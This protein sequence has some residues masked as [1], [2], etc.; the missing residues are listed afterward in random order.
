ME[1]NHESLGSGTASQYL[2]FL[3]ICSMVRLYAS[4]CP[5]HYCFPFPLE[6]SD[7]PATRGVGKNDL[8]AVLR[9]GKWNDS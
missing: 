7:T 4:Q 9:K 8:M 5:N 6:V 1:L 3:K 2:P